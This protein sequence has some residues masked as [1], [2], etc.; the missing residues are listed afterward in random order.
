VPS[1]ATP[2]GADESGDVLVPEDATSQPVAVVEPGA[3]VVPE[4]AAPAE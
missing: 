2:A 1:S 3:P 4:T